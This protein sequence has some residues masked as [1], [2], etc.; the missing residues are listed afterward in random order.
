MLTI[1]SWYFAP[2]KDGDL[3]HPVL[4]LVMVFWCWT[5]LLPSVGYFI[6]V[7]SI[8]GMDFII[9]ISNSSKTFTFSSESVR[10]HFLLLHFKKS[11]WKWSRWKLLNSLLE[12]EQSVFK[13]VVLEFNM[14]IQCSFFN[15]NFSH[16]RQKTIC[17]N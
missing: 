11:I 1:L 7:S 3:A 14:L 15:R 6:R 4:L 13:R 17:W 2:K 16:F 10:L 9:H 5:F 12:I 8:P